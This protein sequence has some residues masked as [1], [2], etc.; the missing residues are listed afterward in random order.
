MWIA[1]P[2][3]NHGGNVP[4]D[5]IP[6]AGTTVN[7]PKCKTKFQINQQ[8]TE[9][10]KPY[11]YCPKCGISQPVSDICIECGIVFLKFLNRELQQKT[12]AQKPTIKTDLVHTNNNKTLLKNA[13][14]CYQALLRDI[15]DGFNHG[16][17][18][19]YY[20]MALVTHN[21]EVA[22]YVAKLQKQV[23]FG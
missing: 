20:N 15:D 18:A 22:E 9:V 17:L 3:C 19:G 12:E 8:A 7:C 5:R 16:F 2:N 21:V 1:C 14:D 11:L 23:G 4:D 6:V 13:T 10:E